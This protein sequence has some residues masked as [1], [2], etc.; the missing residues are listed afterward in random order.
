MRSAIV[1]ATDRDQW[2]A[3]MQSAGADDVYYLPEYHR[4]YEFQGVQCL[5]YAASVGG[6]LLFH[7]FLLRPIARIGRVDAPP[8][9]SD[10]E[11]VYGYSGPVATTASPDFLAEA[12][13]GFEGWCREQNVVCEFIRFSPLLRSE[14]FAA[15]QTEVS[16]DRET[17]EIRLEG[18]EEALWQGYKLAQRNRV[19]K[20]IRRGLACHETSLDEGLATFRDLYES[21]MQRAG[22]SDFYFFPDSYYRDLRRTLSD[23]TKLFVVKYGRDPIAAGLF[24]AYGR[25]LHYHLG[26]S[27]EDALPLAPNN[28][29]FHQVALWGQQHG[30]ERLHLGGG[31]SNAP[32]DA[33]LRFK[34]RFSPHVLT[35]HIGKRIQQPERYAM[36]CDLWQE[37]AGRP[38]PA[39]Y[40]RPYRLIRRLTARPC[41]HRAG[42]RPATGAPPRPRSR[43]R[44]RRQD[45]RPTSVLAG[46]MS[47]KRRPCTAATACHCSRSRR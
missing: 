17:V 27:R 8:G 28:L 35:F 4:L 37:Q 25:T 15:P 19:R 43:P 26:A 18:G 12:W 38:A 33:L 45:R 22:A 24:F 36:L 9:L 44:S 32:D 7:P 3:W 16:L 47:P 5:A 34:K 6:E 42:G 2:L 31:R 11:T 30:F 40:F 20:A 29:M 13:Q 46:R 1:R 23:D 39:G 14:R 41:R 21:T 10:I